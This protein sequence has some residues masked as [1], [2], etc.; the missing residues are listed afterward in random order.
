MNNGSALHP[1]GSKTAIFLHLT[2][3]SV[4]SCFFFAFFRFLKDNQS[5]V[6]IRQLAEGARAHSHQLVISGAAT[7][8]TYGRWNECTPYSWPV[9]G[10]TFDISR[11]RK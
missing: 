6:V 5:D 3:F 8:C 2:R 10:A 9:P 1:G 11:Q 4:Y 7:L